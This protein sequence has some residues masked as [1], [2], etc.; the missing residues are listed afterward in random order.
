MLYLVP[1]FKVRVV[2]PAPTLSWQEQ[3]DPFEA[4][5]VEVRERRALLN[6]GKD[7]QNPLIVLRRTDSGKCELFDTSYI[8]EILEH[9]P[10][11]KGEPF[12]C[13][14]E[15]ARRWGHLCLTDRK[16]IWLGPL[17]EMVKRVIGNMPIA[18][19]EVIDFVKVKALFEKDR[20][21]LIECLPA[22]PQGFY[23]VR[24]KAFE[25]WARYNAGRFM[26]TA[27]Q[28]QEEAT[29]IHSETERQI[30]EDYWHELDM[31]MEETFNS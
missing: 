10:A 8:T 28:L 30:H 25:N 29:V 21:G 26:K 24:R 15:D 3:E 16:G 1:G 14:Q 6:N 22:P 17:T 18:Y 2:P 19:P 31:D 4:E 23:R 11:P 12:N 20:P 5:V 27:K 13:Y 7:K 9:K